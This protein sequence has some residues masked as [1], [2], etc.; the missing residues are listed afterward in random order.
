MKH[1]KPKWINKI[2]KSQKKI[3][4]KDRELAKVPIPKSVK[5]Q[6]LGLKL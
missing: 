5:L 1:T 3:P 4:A 6:K 2:V